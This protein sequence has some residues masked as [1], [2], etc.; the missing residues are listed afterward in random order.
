[1]KIA[2]HGPA[3]GSLQIVRPSRKI[4][5]FAWFTV[6][7][8]IAVILWGAYVRTTG[9]GAGC[10][11][12]WPL[13]N[14]NVIPE[15]AQPQTVVEFVH[16]ITSGSAL[17]M[18]ALLMIWCWR[19]GT[20]RDWTRY[21]SICTFILLMNEALLGAL[22][23][24]TGHVGFD[25]SASRALFLCLHFANTLLLLASLSLTARW[26]SRGDSYFAVRREPRDWIAIGL[27]LASVLT[28]GVTGSL[29]ALGDTIFPIQS[30]QL[31]LIQDFSR[32]SEVLLRLRILHPVSAVLGSIYVLWI[33]LRISRMQGR[34]LRTLALLGALLP[35]QVA[36]GVSNVLLLAPIWLQITHLFVADLLWIS[37][38]FASADLLLEKPIPAEV[39][40][41][42]RT[43]VGLL[44]RVHADKPV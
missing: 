41:R 29:A 19:K 42:H 33:I 34:P 16:R 44:S 2:R 35:V 10:G 24:V 1:M 25:Q 40:V 18:I 43:A 26:L 31:S 39:T 9:A 37:L 23:V 27:G 5:H 7:F 15:M 14:G 6:S 12:H 28:V 20:K 13:C 8:N 22:L 21:S 11:G 17:L 38:V 36:L 32:S 4:A 30:L 3:E